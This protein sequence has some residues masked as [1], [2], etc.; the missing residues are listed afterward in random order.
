MRF[1]NYPVIRLIKVV[2]DTTQSA[3]V[4]FG[5]PMGNTQG[6]KGKVNRC[7]AHVVLRQDSLRLNVAKTIPGYLHN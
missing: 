5:V 7:E 6:E 1:A 4:R 3:S 2:D